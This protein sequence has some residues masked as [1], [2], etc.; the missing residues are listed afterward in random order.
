MF[1]CGQAKSPIRSARGSYK[2]HKKSLKKNS[3]AVG[4]SKEKHFSEEVYHDENIGFVE[5]TSSP[6]LLLNIFE[7]DQLHMNFKHSDLTQGDLRDAN[8]E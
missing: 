7:L 5:T 4:I 6:H 8:G 2:E 3:F 1:C